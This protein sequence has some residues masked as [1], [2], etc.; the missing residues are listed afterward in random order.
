MKRIKVWVKVSGEAGSL[1][2]V[3]CARSL[4]QAEQI[5]QERYLESAV[6]IALPIE[7]DHFFVEGSRHGRYA[8]RVATEGPGEPREVIVAG[9]AGNVSFVVCLSEGDATITKTFAP[10]KGT[11]IRRSRGCHACRSGGRGGGGFPYVC[12][13]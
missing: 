2:V 1:A 3:V 4:R 6:G 5:V 8:G 12:V 13:R 11:R 7:P 10:S 9:M